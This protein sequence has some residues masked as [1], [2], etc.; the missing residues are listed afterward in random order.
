MTSSCRQKIM[1]IC[2]SM[3]GSRWRHKVLSFYNRLPEEIDSPFTNDFFWEV[4]RKEMME[5]LK[6]PESTE[7]LLAE[8][9]CGTGSSAVGF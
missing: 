1:S 6:N 4:P 2:R 3:N 9:G 5:R 8:D 7:E